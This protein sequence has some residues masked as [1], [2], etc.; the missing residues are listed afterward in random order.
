MEFLANFGFVVTS[1]E[2][3]AQGVEVPTITHISW[4]DNIDKALGNMMS[5][6]ITDFFLTATLKGELT[7]RDNKIKITFTDKFISVTPISRYDE[8]LTDATLKFIKEAQ[9]VL[10]IQYELGVPEIMNA[11]SKR[12]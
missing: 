8:V 11:I 5:H 3:N 7:F 6:L 4:G 12:K 2:V 10:N 9:R 1:F